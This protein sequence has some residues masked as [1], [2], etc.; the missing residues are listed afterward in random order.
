MQRVARRRIS[1]SAIFV[2][3]SRSNSF[4]TSSIAIWL[5]LAPNA[6]FREL[7]GTNSGRRFAHPYLEQDGAAFHLQR[8][9]RMVGQDEDRYMVRRI[10]AP[11]SPSHS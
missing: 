5:V 6:R 8:R 3:P 9:A 11:P 1:L 4:S 2:V 10:G 7:A